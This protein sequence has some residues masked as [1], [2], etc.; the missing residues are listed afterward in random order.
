MLSY[1]PYDN[2]RRQPYPA[3][4]VT[5]GLN[6]PRVSFFFAYVVCLGLVLCIETG[7]NLWGVEMVAFEP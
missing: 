6:D 4:L 1:S 3:M 7:H 5:G 2:V